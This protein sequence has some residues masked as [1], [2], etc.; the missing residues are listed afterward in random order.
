MVP[1]LVLG[2]KGIGQGVGRPVP[3]EAGLGVGDPEDA[4][5]TEW[6]GQVGSLGF[7][8]LLDLGQ[9]LSLPNQEAENQCYWVAI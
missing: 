6:L 7:P 2:V 4:E 1:G 5:D 3:Q 8:L 9:V